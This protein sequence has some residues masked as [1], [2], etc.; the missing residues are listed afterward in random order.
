M[1]LDRGVDLEDGWQ[2]W[3]LGLSRPATPCEVLG[4]PLE[5]SRP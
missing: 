5:A 2:A 4:V 3:R 1:V